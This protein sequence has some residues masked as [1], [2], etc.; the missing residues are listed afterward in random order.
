MIYDLKQHTRPII[1]LAVLTVLAACSSDVTG[2]NMHNVQLSFTTNATVAA[3]GNRV[4]ADLV[5]G[6]NDELVL[7]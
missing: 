6:P 1:G 4:A 7:K 3:A 5:V 2:S